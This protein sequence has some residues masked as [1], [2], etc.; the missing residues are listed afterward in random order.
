MATGLASEI[1]VVLAV[2]SAVVKP[3]LGSM[4]V[5]AA[6]LVTLGSDIRVV[7]IVGGRNSG[8]CGSS[9]TDSNSLLHSAIA[10]LDFFLAIFLPYVPPTK[11]N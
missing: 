11:K 1:G 2:T 5:T 10:F 7:S 3:W 6:G 4:L 9:T 8:V